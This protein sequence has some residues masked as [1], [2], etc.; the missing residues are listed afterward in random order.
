MPE[1]PRRPPA[2]MGDTLRDLGRTA[3]SLGKKDKGVAGSQGSMLPDST[4]RGPAARQG[5]KPRQERIGRVLIAIG[6]LVL[7][8]AI[9]GA[10]VVAL[11]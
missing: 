2:P 9:I 5:P 8:V 1:E 6:V 7:I 10:I 4:G 11:T 3:R